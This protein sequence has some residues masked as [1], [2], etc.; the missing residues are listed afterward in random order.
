MHYLKAILLLLMLPSL[1]WAQTAVLGTAANPPQAVVVLAQS[2]IPFIKASSGT[3]GNNCAVSAMT[4]LPRT[5]SGGAY[6]FLP[7][8]AISAGV[9]ASPAWY[10]FVASSTTAG[11]CY[12]NTYSSGQPR[13]PVSPTAFS[14]TGPGAFTGDTSQNVAISISVPGRLIGING[15]LEINATES[16]NN[17]GGNKTTVLRY[18]GTNCHAFVGTTQTSYLPTCFIRNRGSASVQG[19]SSFQVTQGSTALG[20]AQAADGAIDSATAQNAQ[21]TLQTAVATDHAILEGFK[22]VVYPAN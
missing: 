12:N 13:A 21:I 19:M 15:T 6:L 1:T 9:P 17:S 22:I 8:G 14:T 2:G 5:F 10:W 3:M 18:G 7:A 20:Q 11:T 16:N 4:A